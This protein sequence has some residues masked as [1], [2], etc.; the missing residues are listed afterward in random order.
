[1]SRYGCVE[2]ARSGLAPP[3]HNPPSWEQW[4]I[5]E[6]KVSVPN[7]SCEDLT[8]PG[9]VDEVG[10]AAPP[11]SRRAAVATQFKRLVIAIRTGDEAM[12]ERTEGPEPTQPLAGAAGGCLR[13]AVSGSQTSLHQLAL[14]V[15]ANSPGNVSRA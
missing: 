6:N 9:P 4:L 8:E 13:H 7:M 15:G 12:V 2:R 10:A 3:N 11:K 14:D 5:I 1:V